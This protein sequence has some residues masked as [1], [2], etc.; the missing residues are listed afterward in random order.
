MFR[1]IIGVAI[2]VFAFG[3]AFGYMAAKDRFDGPDC[4]QEDSCYAEY[5]NGTWHIIEG[6]Q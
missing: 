2:I 6:E 4:P 5:Y 3:F 1:T